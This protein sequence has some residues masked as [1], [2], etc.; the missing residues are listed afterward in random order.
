MQSPGGWIEILSSKRLLK[1][2]NLEGS[3]RSR[4]KEVSLAQ[5]SRITQ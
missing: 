4:T 1:G 3:C 2:K 5:R